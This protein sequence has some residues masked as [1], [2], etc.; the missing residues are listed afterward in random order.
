MLLCKDESAVSDLDKDRSTSASEAHSE[1]N[2]T[3]AKGGGAGGDARRGTFERA[4][5]GLLVG[6]RDGGCEGEPS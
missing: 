1:K 2:V 3:K 5:G 4:D 6:G